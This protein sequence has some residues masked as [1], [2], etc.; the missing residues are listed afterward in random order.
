M[1]S[2][3]LAALDPDPGVGDLHAGH[4]GRA[5]EGVVRDDAVVVDLELGA[6]HG[7]R[8]LEGEVVPVQ[9]HVLAGAHGVHG[10]LAGDRIARGG[11]ARR[12]DLPGVPSGGLGCGGPLPEESLGRGGRAKAGGQKRRKREGLQHFISP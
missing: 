1:R 8:T 9:H 6:L 12:D 10:R 7:E 2:R 3:L 11:L 5:R 4:L